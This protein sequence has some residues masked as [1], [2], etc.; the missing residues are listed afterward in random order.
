MK[1]SFK[2]RTSRSS[3][4]FAAGFLSLALTVGVGGF[5]LAPA[6]A[7][8]IV[9]AQDTTAPIT[10]AFT[11]TPSAP[12]A[13]KIHAAP[14]TTVSVKALTKS[15]KNSSK[16]VS[17]KK[18]TTNKNGDAIVTG[19]TPGVKYTVQSGTNRITA[20]PESNVLPATSLRVVTTEIPGQLELRWQHQVTAAQGAVGYTVTA[21]PQNDTARQSG[22]VIA[23]TTAPSIVLT[24]LDLD[25]RYEF[26]VTSHNTI[27]T[28]TATKAVMSKSLRDLTG[29]TAPATPVVE[30]QQTTPV[31][32]PPAPAPQ[33][34]GPTTR[35]I[36]VCPDTFTDV[37]GVCQKTAAYTYTNMD[38]TYHSETRTEACSGPD[39]PN[40]QY[41][42]MG[43]SYT[44]PHCPNGGTVHGTTCMAWSTSSRT[45]TVS[46]K[47]STPSGYTDT[48]SH[49]TKKDAIPAGYTDDGTQWVQTTAKIAKEVPA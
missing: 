5:A 11:A 20:I 7:A 12:G 23:E 31:P 49:W 16:T 42:D 6:N 32:P 38:Y 35:T 22:E 19:L 45:V 13:L 37:A 26:A 17:T 29:N 39:C 34:S 8:E 46:V 2:N 3:Q 4:L 21:T 33:P 27:S 25:A 36:Y 18:V 40:S 28:S 44:A 14:K 15:K 47:D 41:M 48:G 10:A 24:D 30:Q 9:V 1:N 43:Y